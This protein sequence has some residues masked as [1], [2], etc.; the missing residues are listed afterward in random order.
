LDLQ[1]AQTAIARKTDSETLCPKAAEKL[2]KGGASEA[3]CRAMLGF[4]GL[5]G[6]RKKENHY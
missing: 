4:L 1:F 5:S 2:P 3:A 6:Y